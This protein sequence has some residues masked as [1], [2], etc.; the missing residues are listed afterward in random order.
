MP[1]TSAFTKKISKM[2][3]LPKFLT[4]V[5]PKKQFFWPRRRRK[6]VPYRPK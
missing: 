2:C 1:Q 3:H 5:M 4:P 6:C